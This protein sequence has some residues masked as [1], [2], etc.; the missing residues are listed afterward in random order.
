MVENQS[1]YPINLLALYG[2]S[3]DDPD[4]TFNKISAYQIRNSIAD[5]LPEIAL[6]LDTMGQSQ[7]K[8]IMQ[9]VDAYFS[10]EIIMRFEHKF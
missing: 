6:L 8:P 7:H 5:G 10:F 9:Q 2:K 4:I 1:K 3:L